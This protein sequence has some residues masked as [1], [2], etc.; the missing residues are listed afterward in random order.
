MLP[1]AA[2]LPPHPEFLESITYQVVGLVVVF[3]A[4]GAIWLLMELMGALFRAADARRARP[5]PAAPLP[6]TATA[7]AGDLRPE[8]IAVITAAVHSSID[9]AATIVAITPVAAHQETNLNLLAWSS[10][11]RR[12]IFASHKLR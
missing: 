3:S 1:L 12:Q 4:L 9:S 6:S 2:G 10:E 8:L 7:T 5:L 11:G